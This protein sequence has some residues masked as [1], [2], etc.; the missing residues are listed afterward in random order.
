MCGTFVQVAQRGVGQGGW[1]QVAPRENQGVEPGRKSARGRPGVGTG[2][3]AATG[4]GDL[5]HTNQKMNDRIED[6]RRLWETVP[7]VPDLQCAWQLLVQSAN[8]RTNHSL[9]TMPPSCTTEHA[10]AFD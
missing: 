9:R 7:S 3:L 6:E 4:P 10:R 8:P 1:R 2:C 5:G